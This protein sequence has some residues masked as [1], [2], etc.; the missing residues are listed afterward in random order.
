[1][2]RRRVKPRATAMER[3]RPREFGQDD[4]CTKPELWVY[5]DRTTTLLLRYLHMSVEVGRLPSILGREFF[6]AHVTSYR[7]NTFEDAV[8]FVHDVERSLEQLDAFSQQMIARIV[9]QEHTRAEA[10]RLLGCAEKTVS[11]RFPQALDKLSEIF[12]SRGLLREWE[13]SRRQS[14]RPCQEPA[15]EED[16]TSSCKTAV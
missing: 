16:L 6:R 15:G 5:R 10:A 1:M 12:L 14:R 4:C 8:I 9:L 2:R 7:V 11:R 13:T 3:N